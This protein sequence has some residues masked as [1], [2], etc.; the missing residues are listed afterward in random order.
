MSRAQSLQ[1]LLKCIYQN[2]DNHLKKRLEEKQHENKGESHPTWLQICGKVEARNFIPWNLVHLALAM[3]RKWGESTIYMYMLVRAKFRAR[4]PKRERE[5][6]SLLTATLWSTI[7]RAFHPALLKLLL[8]SISL[9][10]RSCRVNGARKEESYELAKY[11]KPDAQSISYKM[12]KKESLN[13]V[14][15]LN[16]FLFPFPHPSSF[17]SFGC[18]QRLA[19]D[20]SLASAPCL[21]HKWVSGQIYSRSRRS[22]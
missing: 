12:R 16:I 1:I 18:C 10:G 14:S 4:A 6:S 13:I 3:P 7:S 2:N 21:I 11:A 19:R 5:R 22:Q 15:T 8:L 20:S 17:L 9:M